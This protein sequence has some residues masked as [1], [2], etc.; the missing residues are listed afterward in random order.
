MLRVSLPFN[1]Q[2][3]GLLYHSHSTF[4]P[5]PL[6]YWNY[7][8]T[9]T[10]S[11]VSNITNLVQ[12]FKQPWVNWCPAIWIAMKLF[13]KISSSKYFSPE[14]DSNLGPSRIAATEDCKATALTTQPPRLVHER[15]KN[16]TKNV[17]LLGA[18]WECSWYIWG[19]PHL[20]YLK[21]YTF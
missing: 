8:N 17:V 15:V 9:Q 19:W 2:D 13:F 14:Q 11:C 1:P 21:L 10:H 20:I 4:C 5:I 12:Y 16:K 6:Q 18:Y 3:W 7:C